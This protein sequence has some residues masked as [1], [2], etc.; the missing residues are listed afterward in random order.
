MDNLG[1]IRWSDAVILGS[2]TNKQA[3]GYF[4]D[5]DGNTCVRGAALDAIGYPLNNVTLP[6]TD[7]LQVLMFERKIWP[8]MYD[9]SV[10]DF[11]NNPLKE[12][13]CITPPTLSLKGYVTHLND[14]HLIPR[15]KIAAIIRKFED[16]LPQF[17][18]VQNDDIQLT[19]EVS[20]VA[21]T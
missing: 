4:K 6:N 18:T 8:Y 19:K 5:I 14:V 2:L 11:P 12:C 3:Q 13:D 15:P 16:T 17:Q 10:K 21:S 7:F 9:Y 1:S 20:N